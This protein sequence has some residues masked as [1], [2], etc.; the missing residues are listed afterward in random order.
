[1]DDFLSARHLCETLGGSYDDRAARLAASLERTLTRLRLDRFGH[2]AGIINA[3]ENH[4][5]EGDGD[6]AV[7]RH[8]GDALLALAAVHQLEPRTIKKL[9]QTLGELHGHVSLAAQARAQ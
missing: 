8:L 5:E 9:T 2:F 6:P 1:M 7:V 4:V 3:I